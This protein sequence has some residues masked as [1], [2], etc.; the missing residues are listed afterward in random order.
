MKQLLVIAVAAAFVLGGCGSGSESASDTQVG[1]SEAVAAQAGPAQAGATPSQQPGLSPEPI[2]HV[3]T[4]PADYPDTWFFAEDVNFSNMVDGKVVILD[5]AAGTRE[6]KG[7]LPA[8]SAASFAQSWKRHELY[9]AETIH[10]LRV[11]GPRHDYL[12]VYDTETLNPIAQVELPAKRFQ[13]MPFNSS[14]ILIDD[15]R[16]ALIYN[17]TPA[18][19]VTVVD[20][21]QR[22]VLSEVQIPGCAMMF[23]IGSRGFS[24]ICG[25]ARLTTIHL[26]ENGVVAS[27]AK[28]APFI[29]I[30]N[31]AMFMMNAEYKGIRYFPTYLGDIQPIDFNSERPKLLKKWS[32]LTQ[33]ERQDGLRPGGWQLIAG[34][35]AGDLY[36]LVHSGGAEGTHKNPS[37]TVYVYSA[38][39]KKRVRTLTLEKPA[40]SIEVT[41]GEI[42][43]LIAFSVDMNLDVYDA[44]TGAHL[45]TLGG[46]ATETAFGLYAV[47]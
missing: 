3:L 13:G 27:E 22:K 44:R 42:P 46:M 35:S 20:L 38:K 26:D 21:E 33:Q 7:Q 2:P 47:Q 11:R 8:G 37:A 36:V 25:D 34:D 15:D 16:L 4:L 30:D 24:T 14:M 41:K 5:A 43:Y 1:N 23:P 19:S 17:F 12:F 32:L 6:Y 18:A 9:V 28:T 29:D 39:D 31:N 40:I 45:R 10:E